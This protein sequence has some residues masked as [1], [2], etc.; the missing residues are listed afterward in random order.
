MKIC[1]SKINSRF[2]SLKNNVLICYSKFFSS[3][4]LVVLVKEILL[5]VVQCKYCIF[6]NALLDNCMDFD[7]KGMEPLLELFVYP[8]LYL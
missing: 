4:L 2:D 6:K 3:A 5:F 1:F 8:I 7:K